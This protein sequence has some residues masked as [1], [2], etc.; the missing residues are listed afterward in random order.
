M[1]RRVVLL[2]STG[3]IGTQAVDVIGRNPDRFEVTAL[4]AGGS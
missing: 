3:S 4:A 1:C 2:G